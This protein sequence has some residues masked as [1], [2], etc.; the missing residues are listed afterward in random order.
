MAV[1]YRKFTG[2][3]CPKRYMG[4]PRLIQQGVSNEELQV[5]NTLRLELPGTQIIRGDRIVLQGRE[6][7]AYLPEYKLGFEYDGLFWHNASQ[8]KDSSYHLHKTILAE[9]QGV[10]LMHIWSNEWELNRPIVVDMIKKAIGKALPIKAQECTFT[11]LGKA[12]ANEFMKFCH[13]EGPDLTASKSFGLVYNGEIVMACQM[14]KAEDWWEITRITDR[15]GVK[16]LD[17]FERMCSEIRAMS[18]QFGTDIIAVC[19][20]RFLDAYQYKAAGCKEIGC[21]NPH[22]WYTKD[23]KKVYSEDQFANYVKL[24]E[25]KKKPITVSEWQ[26]VWDCGQRRFCL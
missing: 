19:N 12:E 18:K 4:P 26:T 11:P 10:K 14:A 7:D 15:R 17:G 8:G 24:Q 9:Q 6:I 16:V 2:A 5:F 23:Y 3:K 25:S 1:R 20:R 21:T 22:R 13:I